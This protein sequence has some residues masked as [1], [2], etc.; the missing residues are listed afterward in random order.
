MCGTARRRGVLT[1]GAS[2]GQSGND[3]GLGVHFVVVEETVDCDRRKKKVIKRD[4]SG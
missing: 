4:W 3:E 1:A 2:D